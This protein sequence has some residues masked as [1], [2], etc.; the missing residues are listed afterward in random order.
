M[1]GI[2]TASFGALLA[3]SLNAQ[4][5]VI[6]RQPPNLEPGEEYRLMFL[7]S[8][9]RDATSSEIEDYNEFV[10]LVAD[11]SPEV[12]SWN[13]EWKAIVSTD[14]VDA[15][16]NTETNA[17][18]E[19]G[20]PIYGVHGQILASNYN[21]LWNP[22]DNL[23]NRFSM[24]VTELGTALF[25]IRPD[26]DALY[27]WTG[28]DLDGT[29]YVTSDRGSRVGFLGSEWAIAGRAAAPPS[30]LIF[31]DGWSTTRELPL[32]AISEIITAVPEATAGEYVATFVLAYF[33]FFRRRL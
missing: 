28:T 3:Y 12:G 23:D 13:L 21:V 6:V 5:Q 22:A 33:F 15:R 26:D 27:A 25:L 9:F 32:F 1:R 4:A 19:L 20:V 14:D 10:Q 16:D 18:N 2:S 11:D 29:A 8:E 7:T 24:N 17:A 31:G 30:A